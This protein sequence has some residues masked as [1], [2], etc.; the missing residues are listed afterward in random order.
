MMSRA[1][2]R[3]EGG[4]GTKEEERDLEENEEEE[5]HRKARREGEDEI[6][7]IIAITNGRRATTSTA[8]IAAWIGDQAVDRPDLPY[9]IRQ[10][11]ATVL[12]E[13][14]IFGR[15]DDGIEVV[16][17]KPMEQRDQCHPSSQRRSMRSATTINRSLSNKS[18]ELAPKRKIKQESGAG[19]VKVLSTFRPGAGKK[20]KQHNVEKKEEEGL[21]KVTQGQASRSTTS[22][23]GATAATAAAAAAAAVKNSQGTEL[24]VASSSVSASIPTAADPRQNKKKEPIYARIRKAKED[25]KILKDELAKLQLEL[26]AEEEEL[27]LLEKAEARGW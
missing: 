8:D 25:A 27:A 1:E 3:G 2:E 9:R 12:L 22:V 14:R 18:S 10:S 5:R 4:D 13:E 21:V 23:A 16:E 20:G 19:K 11:A 6:D 7:A 17:K 24:V 15:C 26:D